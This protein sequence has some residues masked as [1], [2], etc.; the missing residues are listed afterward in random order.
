VIRR[1]THVL[2]AVSAEIEDRLRGKTGR[3]R[4]VRI[5]NGIE[6]DRLPKACDREGLLRELSLPEGTV[7]FGAAG[8]LVPVKGIDV[9]LDA[10]ARLAPDHPEHRFLLVGD[11]PSREELERRAEELGIADRVLFLGHR[12][13][14]E[15]IIGCLDALVM[16]SMHEGMPMALLEAR[17]LGVP[18]AASRTG[19]IAEAVSSED[20]LLVE[21]GDAAALAEALRRIRSFPRRPRDRFS[22]G[23]T[24]EFSASRMIEDY[25]R[26]YE[27]EAAAIA[28]ASR[29]EPS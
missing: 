4:L 13:D 12:N 21:P 1:G 20:G 27:E 9:L 10:A 5:R 19:G 18:I 11:G 17:A 29:S 14:A 15:R 26:V 2:V 25:V 22:S 23:E 3:A 16:P 6:R 8:R 24:D 7:L 28:R